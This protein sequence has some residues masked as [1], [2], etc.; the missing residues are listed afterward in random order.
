ML[1]ALRSRYAEDELAAAAQSGASQYIIL[2]AGL[3]SYAYRRPDAM[4]SLRIYEVDHPASQTWKRA[5]LAELE[6]DAPPTLRYVPVNFERETLTDGLAA[7]GWTA[8]QEP[9]SPGSA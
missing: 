6:I 2:G 9:F 5:R 3:D 1:F 7:G 4:R 8:T